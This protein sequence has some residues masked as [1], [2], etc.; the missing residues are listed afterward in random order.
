MQQGPRTTLATQPTNKDKFPKLTLTKN[1]RLLTLNYF[2]VLNENKVNKI[3]LNV[4]VN[5]C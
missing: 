5:Y 1:N 2:Y 3:N 4:P